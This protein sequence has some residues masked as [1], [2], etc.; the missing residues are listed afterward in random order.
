[1]SGTEGVLYLQS[2]KWRWRILATARNEEMELTDPGNPNNKMRVHLPFSWRSL[3]SDELLEMA[4]RPDMR[5]WRDREGI[6]WRISAVGP[7]TS[8]DIPLRSRHLV[9]DSPQT[10]AGLVDFPGPAELGDL[11]SMD[12]AD[13]RDHAGD[14]GGPRRRLR[15]AREG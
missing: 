4:R 2:G 5:L 1:M 15:V 3:S 12:L 14:F 13:A 11:T 6:L 10:W 9:F 8:Y 7:G